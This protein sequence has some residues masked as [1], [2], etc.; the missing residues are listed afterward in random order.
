ML[1]GFWKWENCGSERFVLDQIPNIWGFRNKYILNTNLRTDKD[2]HLFILQ[3][4]YI[5]RERRKREK[6]RKTLP[7]TIISE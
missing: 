2:C 5:L 3:D 6:G 7:F 1:S 4:N